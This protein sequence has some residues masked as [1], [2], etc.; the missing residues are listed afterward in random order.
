[1]LARGLLRRV[2][3]TVPKTTTNDLPQLARLLQRIALAPN[4]SPLSAAPAVSRGLSAAIAEFRR[5]YATTTEATKPTKTVKKAVKKTA[6]KKT[7]TKKA[8]SKKTAKKAAPKKK[9][10]AAAAKKKAAPRRKK[11]ELTAEEKGKEAIRELK[12]KALRMPVKGR[13]IRPVHVIMKELSAGKKGLTI[14]DI[15]RESLA[16]VEGLSPAELEVGWP[17][18][19]L[20][21]PITDH[22]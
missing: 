22:V 17:A 2:A 16:K 21:L 13:G 15:Q 12:R 7:A 8:A 3:V 18:F 6:A 10:K 20:S 19:P 14:Q 4:A 5:S 1:M 11:K 9:K